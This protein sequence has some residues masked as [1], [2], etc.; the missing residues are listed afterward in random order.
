MA[1]H[2]NYIYCFL[3]ENDRTVKVHLI[4]GVKK[5]LHR[6][7]QLVLSVQS[8]IRL[9]TCD[10]R[11]AFMP[12]SKYCKKILI[13]IVTGSTEP[14]CIKKK[15]RKKTNLQQRGNCGFGN[16][17]EQKLIYTISHHLANN[18]IEEND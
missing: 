8:N 9:P 16:S 4:L 7:F 18:F 11:A 13:V 17:I 2:F 1:L 10:R 15:N 14:A 6:P 3:G 5:N 12:M